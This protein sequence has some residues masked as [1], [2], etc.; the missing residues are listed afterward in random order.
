M[1]IDLHSTTEESEES[2]HSIGLNFTVSCGIEM[3][4]SSI[5]V[6]IKVF[7]FSISFKSKMGL[8]N[9]LGSHESC[10]VV[11]VEFSSRLSL[12]DRSF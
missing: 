2:T 3:S 1:E 6:L 9:F 10:G 8:N 7:L 12:W 11:E 4:E 5:E